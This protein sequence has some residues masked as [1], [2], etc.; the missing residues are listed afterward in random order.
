ME[1][2]TVET[3]AG[4]IND[5][6]SVLAI[7]AAAWW[8]FMTTKFKPRIQFDLGCDFLSLKGN[9]DA[10]IA[11]LQFIV[12]NKGFVEHRLYHLHVSVHTL[13]SE[14]SLKEKEMTRELLFKKQLLPKVT[15]VPKRYGYYFVRPGARQVI[16]HI[17]TVP[18][19]ISVMRVTASFDYDRAGEH[20]HTSRKVFDVR[21]SSAAHN[22]KLVQ[23][24]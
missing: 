2:E 8:F 22:N 7:A 21:G 24:A 6:I 20:H 14:E 18:K 9:D 13:E 11:E 16:T 1:L 10:L 5:L 19:S 17:I 12:E 3:W 15:I 23:P 4:I